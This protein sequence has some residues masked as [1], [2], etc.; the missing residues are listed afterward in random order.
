LTHYLPKPLL[1]VTGTPVISHTLGSLGKAGCEKVAIN[2]FYQGEKIAARLGNGFGDME[3][4]YSREEELLGT[5][6]ALAPLKKFLTSA[7]L[8][9][10]VNGDSLCRWPLKRLL[11]HHLRSQAQ[12]TL[13]LSSRASVGSFGGGVGLDREGQIV[14][15]SEKRSWGEVDRRR[16]FAGVH[17]FSPELVAN[18]EIRPAGFIEDL[19]SPMLEASELIHAVET[20]RPWFDLGTP[21]GYLVG[22]CKWAQRRGPAGVASRS[23]VAGEAAVD[24]KANLRRAVVETGA[25]VET[26]AEVERSVILSEAV[27]SEDCRVRDSIVGFGA[28]LPRATVV[29]RRMVTVARADVV[30]RQGDSVVGGLVYSPLR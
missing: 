25:K 16:V 23:W 15:F 10:V 4:V 1:P 9:V 18:L 22:A 12:A 14:S 20:S 30:P 29:E 19:Y 24:A 28:R 8:V 26:R 2:L 7:E 17:V 21:A 11:R 6:G 5:L 13:L 27:I 3:I